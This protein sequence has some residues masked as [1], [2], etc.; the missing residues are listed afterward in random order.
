MCLAIRKNTE[1]GAFA[2]TLADVVRSS[3]ER[4]SARHAS[5]DSRRCRPGPTTSSLTGSASTAASRTAIRAARALSTQFASW[6]ARVVAGDRL[7]NPSQEKK[8]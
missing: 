5:A 1:E 7:A 4:A 2:A 6:V 3:S 8:R